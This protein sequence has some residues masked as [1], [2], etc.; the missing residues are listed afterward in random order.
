[1]GIFFLAC[2]LGIKSKEMTHYFEGPL[3]TP[4][5][6]YLKIEIP[7]L[8]DYIPKVYLIMLYNLF[9]LLK[10]HEYPINWKMNNGMIE[11]MEKNI[12]TEKE[13]SGMGKQP[14]PHLLS[15]G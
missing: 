12:S 3:V 1:M 4:Q 15:L 6:F 2:G 7:Y 5:F 9:C 10:M 8:N 14:F 11:K 13:M